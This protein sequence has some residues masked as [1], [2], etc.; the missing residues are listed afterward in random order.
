[1]DKVLMPAEPPLEL[2]NRSQPGHE[3]DEVLFDLC[4]DDDYPGLYREFVKRYAIKE[5]MPS[6]ERMLGASR[7]YH[8]A[9]EAKHEK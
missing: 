9:E 7:A 4:R 5:G 2:T 6:A 3:F 8:A 1:M